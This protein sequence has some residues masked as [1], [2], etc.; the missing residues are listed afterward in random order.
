MHAAA[1]HQQRI[2]STLLYLL[3]PPPHVGGELLLGGMTDRWLAGRRCAVYI[4]S[5][6]RRLLI[7]C[8]GSPLAS[9]GP[10]G[11]HA[12]RDGLVARGLELVPDVTQLGA[13]RSGAPAGT[14]SSACSAHAPL[15]PLSSSPP[16]VIGIGNICHVD[17]LGS[18]PSETNVEV[19]FSMVPLLIIIRELPAKGTGIF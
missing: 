15:G 1:A 4:N 5:M 19:R 14:V 17:P 11:Q 9:T 6:Q 12:R 10:L 2:S 7:A 18:V 13:C 8:T 16:R 3:R